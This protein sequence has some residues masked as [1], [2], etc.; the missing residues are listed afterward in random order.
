MILAAILVA[1]TTVTVSALATEP[2]TPA[3]IRPIAD[4][5]TSANSDAAYKALLDKEH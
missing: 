5:V 4:S 2:L 3:Q 1:G